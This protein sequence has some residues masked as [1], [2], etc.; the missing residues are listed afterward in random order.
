MT[1]ATALTLFVVMDIDRQQCVFEIYDSIRGAFDDVHDA[2]VAAVG[3]V[4]LAIETEM[5]LL[6]RPETMVMQ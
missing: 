2:F 3:D 6:E 1:F 5:L 4:A